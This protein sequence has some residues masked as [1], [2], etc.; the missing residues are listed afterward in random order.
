MGLKKNILYNSVLTISNYIFPLIVYPYVS[1]VLGV[2][3]I[4]LCN[5]ID[6]IINYVILFSMMGITIMGNRIIAEDRARNESL[7]SSFSSIFALNSISTLVSLGILFVGVILVPELSQQKEMMCYGGIKVVS[8]FLLIEWF[9]RGLEDFKYITIRTIFVKC[10]YVVAI[11]LLVKSETDYKIYYL[12]TVLMVSFNAVINIWYSRNFA[13]FKFRLIK[14]KTILKPFFLLGAYMLITSFCRSFNTVFLG[15]V[16]NDTQVGYF[17]TATKLFSIFLALFTA[18]TVVIMPRM[19]NL[20]ASEEIEVFKSLLKKTIK[21]LFD[22][23]IPL[24]IFSIIF[25]P[26]IIY[27]ISGPGYEGASTPMRI[28][29]LMILINGYEQ[30][31]VIQ[32]LMPLNKDKIIMYISSGGAVVSIVLNILLVPTLES[33]GAAIAMTSA[34]FTVLVLSQV[35]MNKYIQIKFPFKE[36]LKS[37][38]SY[39]PLTLILLSLYFFCPII[40][41]ADLLISGGITLIY[42]VIIQFFIDKN[43]YLLSLTGKLQSKFQKL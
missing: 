13:K 24:I 8:N 35:Y 27:L 9:Y 36:F 15:F 30:I 38:V 7:D 26:Q 11:F 25:S 34:E 22:F 40:Y 10:L 43:P 39:I 17:T 29:M 18:A 14:F 21:I 6:S 28:I 32:C 4:G 42:F 1:R 2:T 19:S 31:T 20:L 23:S 37:I 33:V 3:N 16:K 41:W 12:L 5:F